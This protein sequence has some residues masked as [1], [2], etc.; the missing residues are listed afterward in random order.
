MSELIDIVKDIIALDEKIILIYGFNRIGKTRLS[1][2]YK[3]ETKVN[4]EIIGVYYNAYSED[5]FY[6]ENALNNDEEMSDDEEKEIKLNVMRSSLD[7]YHSFLTEDLVKDKLLKYKM[8]FDFIFDFIKGSEQIIEAIKFFDKDNNII[9]IS[10]GEE[11]I[12][13]WCFFLCLFEE[14]GLMDIKKN[15][16]FF[17]DDPVSN[18][19]EYNLFI[20]ALDIIELIKKY[21]E[22][23][24][25]IITTHQISFFSMLIN[26][27]KKYFSGKKNKMKVYHLKNENGYELKNFNNELFLYHLNLLQQLD[28]AIKNDQI[29]EFHFVLLRQLLENIASYLGAPHFSYVL[30]LLQI[31]NP[32]SVAE[33]INILSH[34]NIFNYQMMI[35][36]REHEEII[37]TICDKLINQF[38]FKL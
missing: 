1:Y 29:L 11:Q 30:N 3:E 24:K 34:K 27:V 21:S 6:W 15:S 14:S 18:L 8:N 28:T 5:L 37:K 22:Q 4:G 13:R 19:D 12:F 26:G 2:T 20:L 9:K 33:Q 36:P 25:I 17:I 32:D 38:K 31:E 16:Y 23:I 35:A 7:K 10:R